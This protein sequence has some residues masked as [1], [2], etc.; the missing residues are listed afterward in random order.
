MKLLEQEEAALEDGPM[1]AMADWI[2]EQ[3]YALIDADEE[4]HRIDPDR[5]E[6]ERKKDPMLVKLRFRKYDAHAKTNE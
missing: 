1:T 2:G 6:K 5:P 4:A 3:A